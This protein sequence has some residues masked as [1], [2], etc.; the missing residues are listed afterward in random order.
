MTSPVVGRMTMIMPPLE[1]SGSPV[2]AGGMASPLRG[3]PAAGA[4]SPRKNP[5]N[6]DFRRFF[7]RGDLP[8]AIDPRS[9]KR[10]LMWTIPPERVDAAHFLPVFADGLREEE[11]PY[12]FVASSGTVA[13]IESA[14]ASGRLLPIIPALIAPLR[15]AL[16]TRRPPVM[17][18]AL[19]ALHQMITSDVRAAAGAGVA[20]AVARSLIPYLRQLLPVLNIFVG[21]NRNLGDGIEYGQRKGEV[22]GDR[23]TELLTAIETYGGE[24]A[25]VNIKYL[26]PTWCSVGH[27]GAAPAA[28]GHGHGHG[29][30]AGGAGAPGSR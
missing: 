11:Y 26:I 15:N 7:E 22:L 19:G 30:A 1:V 20:P 2:L 8:C 4:K 23:I 16:N 14:A 28:H 5:P 6:T 27:P 9:A 17:L 29:G 25:F 3:P 21:S 18:A 24:D 10:R 13:L 12:Q